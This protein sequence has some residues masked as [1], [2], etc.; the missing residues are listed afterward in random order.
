MVT[1]VSERERRVREESLFVSAVF[2]P[3][4]AGVRIVCEIV[5]VCESQCA[6]SPLVD[7]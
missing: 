3:P 2:K 1:L 7:I 4:M 6:R 5:Y